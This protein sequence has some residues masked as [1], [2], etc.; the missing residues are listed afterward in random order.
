MPATLRSRQRRPVIGVT[1]GVG[2]GKSTVAALFEKWGGLLISGDE[3]GRQV[4]DRSILLRRR[5][6]RVFG[7]DILE[8]G[9][10]RR[11]ILAQ[12]A[13]ANPEAAGKLNGLVH[14]L[15][16]REL[17]RQIETARRSPRHRAVIV[18]A[19]LLPEWGKARIPWDYLVGVWAPRTQRYKRLRQ[20]GWSDEEIESRMREQM[21]WS[22]RRLVVDRVVKNDGSIDQLERRARFCWRNIVSS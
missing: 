6:A 22:Q 8:G 9:I 12:R 19:A 11:S 14:P 2:A 20:R 10:L 4:V 3:I 13:F 15:L 18:D 16:L 21:P 7:D 5:L 1:G 17:N